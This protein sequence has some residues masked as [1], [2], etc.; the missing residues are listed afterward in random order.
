MSRA[1][2]EAQAAAAAMAMVSQDQAAAAATAA[3]WSDAFLS[4]RYDIKLALVT[5]ETQHTSNQY[6]PMQA[7]TEL[8]YRVELLNRYCV[9]EAAVLAASKAATAMCACTAA[10]AA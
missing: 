9:C 10:V 8:E 7:A 5:Y 1:A 2:E 6:V 3:A 4:G